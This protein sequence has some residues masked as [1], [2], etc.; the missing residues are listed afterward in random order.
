MTRNVV[1]Y[2]LASRVSSLV[3]AGEYVTPPLDVSE[4][5]TSTWNLWRGALVGGSDVGFTFEESS[6]SGD[7][8]TCPGADED[9]DPGANSESRVS[10]HHHR[11]WFRLRV[12]LPDSGS[13]VSY[14]V[15]GHFNRPPLPDNLAKAF[16]TAS[17]VEDDGADGYLNNVCTATVGATEYAFVSAGTDGIHIIE[18][19]D[20][21]SPGGLTYLATISSS[22]IGGGKEIAGD[23]SD[24]L[25]IVDN[26]HLVSL[27]IGSGAVDA[28]SNG[29]TV[30]DIGE[31]D[32]ILGGSTPYDFQTAILT[33]TGSGVIAIP[34]DND[35]GG[36][37]A[38][39]NGVFVVA[40]GGTNA[41]VADI[42]SGSPGT[43][44][45]RS[46]I[47]MSMTASYDAAISG[48][49]AYVSARS[50]SD[51]G[52]VVLD[53]DT[54]DA[55][56]LH[57]VAG[58]FSRYADC[59]FAGRGNFA[60]SLALLDDVL[61]VSGDDEVIRFDMSDP[62]TPALLAPLRDAGVNAVSLDVNS[63]LAAVGGDFEVRTY[64]VESESAVPLSRNRVG[65]PLRVLGVAVRSDGTLLC[66]AGNG[67]LR[68]VRP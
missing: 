6:G 47:D 8:T 48:S 58:R 55:S 40:T 43:W 60:L 61:L 18:V 39:D 32:S 19:E 2:V 56:S 30:F 49:T 28:N 37:V 27:A 36:G 44:Q 4:F 46:A 52:V 41:G 22:T 50:G 65:D 7:W 42:T 5:E 33:R 66:A 45:A 14:W 23:R 34:G 16:E 38:G 62:G 26:T 1:P 3:G 20:I 31:I 11:R 63:S 67:G 35:R 68:A 53:L 9:H 17:V 64:R 10:V 51:Y 57:E 29:V 24:A 12:S 15:A 25:A 59:D 54:P 13:M 21:Q